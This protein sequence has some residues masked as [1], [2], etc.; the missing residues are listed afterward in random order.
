MLRAKSPLL[1]ITASKTRRQQR[2]RRIWLVYDSP[3]PEIWVT[4]LD[5]SIESF[6]QSQGRVSTL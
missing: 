5:V 6:C 4:V 2:H 1:C 3:A